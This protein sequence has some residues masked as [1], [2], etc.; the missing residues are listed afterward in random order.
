MKRTLAKVCAE[1]HTRPRSFALPLFFQKCRKEGVRSCCRCRRHRPVPLVFFLKRERGG[2]SK[3]KA[4]KK[5]FKSLTRSSLS[6]A[7]S[8][9]PPPPRAASPLACMFS[10]KEFL[11]QNGDWGDRNRKTSR[12]RSAPGLG[13]TSSTSE[14]G[15]TLSTFFFLL[16]S[17][18]LLL[19]F[20]TFHSFPVFFVTIMD[21]GVEMASNL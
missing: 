2:E 7:R 1:V 5:L 20:R 19:F 14:E 16:L 13:T 10:K 17:A 12:I 11:R 4:K 3:K 9:P 21:R 15:K 18:C 6:F 8:P